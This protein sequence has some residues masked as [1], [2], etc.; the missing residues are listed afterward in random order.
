[1]KD[2]FLDS[3]L[4]RNWHRIVDAEKPWWGSMAGQNKIKLF[5]SYLGNKKIAP[6]LWEHHMEGDS[7]GFCAVNVAP[8][9]GVRNDRISNKLP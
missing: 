4:F 5:E 1:M 7:Q 3:K 2:N 9:N 6:H 8:S